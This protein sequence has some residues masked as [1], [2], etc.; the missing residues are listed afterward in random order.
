MFNSATRFL[1]GKSGKNARQDNAVKGRDLENKAGDE[2]SVIETFV[3]ETDIF[4]DHVAEYQFDGTQDKFNSCEVEVD[5]VKDEV[6]SF[7][8]I[9]HKCQYYHAC[10]HI[11]DILFC[12]LDCQLSE[13]YK[14]I[15]R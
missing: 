15:G 10:I 4:I 3:D 5:A 7:K 1:R 9:K 12:Y 14:C 11:Y 13:R 6:I 8:K 2:D